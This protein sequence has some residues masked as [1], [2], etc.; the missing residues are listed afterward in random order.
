MWLITTVVEAYS[1]DGTLSSLVKNQYC[2][3]NS[4]CGHNSTVPKYKIHWLRLE[5]QPS[6][7]AVALEQNGMPCLQKTCFVLVQCQRQRSCCYSP[8]QC[9]FASKQCHNEGHNLDIYNSIS[10]CR[11]MSL[12]SRSAIDDDFLNNGVS[13]SNAEQHRKSSEI[14]HVD[15]NSSQESSDF[16]VQQRRL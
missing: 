15:A 12:D 5:Q 14:L 1:D 7:L 8:I 6:E 9:A 3:G 11:Q 4:P 16:H 13:G 2:S 10:I